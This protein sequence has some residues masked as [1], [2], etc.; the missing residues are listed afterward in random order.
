VLRRRSGASSRLER[1]RRPI[2]LEGVTRP[3]ALFLALALT[4]CT[5]V[6]GVT[7]TA[8]PTNTPDIQRAKLDLIYSALTDQDL[9]KVTS[10]KA[11]EMA[12]EFVRKEV[13]RTGGSTDVATPQFGD[14]A[15]TNLG[16]FRKFADALSAIAAKNPQLSGDD[17]A[18]ASITGML[19]ATP[20]C[21]TY[22]FD[23]RRLDSRP[24]EETGVSDPAP[25]QGREIWPRD[26]AGLTARIIEGGVA[27]IRF[28][29]FLV[30]GT[31]DIREKVKAVL[32]RALAEGATAWLFDLRGNGGGNGPEF[33]ASYFLNGETLMDVHYRSGFGGS[34]R[35][36]PELRLPEPYQLP[37][38]VVLNGRGGSGP[39]VFGLFLKEAKRATIIGKRTVGCLGATSPTHMP[40]GSQIS[41]VVEEYVGAVTKTKYNNAGIEPDIAADDSSAVEVARRH[42]LA[43]IAAR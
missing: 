1:A 13:E 25:P 43:E 18:V 15:E 34:K 17:I 33:I 7:G 35:A 30:T 23:G 21:H 41:V 32:E 31:Y 14:V 36:I 19:R 39:E 24:I 40:D 37:I 38:A 29:A 10:K 6:P 42:L 26:Q 16:D 4:T 8:R 12:L 22:Y 3:L 11:L 27:Y 5:G 20:D 9:H 2:R 28:T